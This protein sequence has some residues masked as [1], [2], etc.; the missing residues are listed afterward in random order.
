MIKEVSYERLFSFGQ[1]ENE[2]VRMTATVDE[3]QTPTQVLGELVLKILGIEDVLGA[4][5]DKIRTVDS[6]RYQKAHAETSVSDTERHI[7]EMKVRI[8]DISAR[9]ARG[10]LD[11]DGKLRHACDRESY[12]DLTVRLEQY[13]RQVAGSEKVLELAIND[14]DLLKKR[15]KEGNFDLQGISVVARD[16]GDLE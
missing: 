5:R 11:V 14:R 13:K 15:I 9:L 16:H 12:K 7:D 3:G 2:K 8:E 6:E 10:E 4:Y 1:Y